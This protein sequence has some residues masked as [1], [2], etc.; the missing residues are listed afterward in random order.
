MELKT[1]AFRNPI[2]EDG[3]DPWVVSKDGYY[4]YTHTTG[5]NITLWKSTSLTGIP[6]GISKVVW[7]PPESGPQ[8]KNIWAPEIHWINDKWYIYF[9]ADDGENEN[10]RMYVLESE[11][12][13]PFGPYMNRGKIADA[14]DKWAIDGTV[15]RKDSGELFFIWSGWEGDVNVRQ[16]LY[17]APM[18]NPYT[19]SGE[20]VEIS[21]PV[22]DW[23]TIGEPHVNEGPVALVRN[24]NIYLIYSA[25]GSWTDDYC[26]GM[27]SADA[28]SDLLSPS[29]WRKH[30]LPVFSK[31]EDVFGPGHNSFVRSPDGT[32]DWIVYHAAKSKG[33]GWQRNVRMQ[34]FTWNDDLTPNLGSPVSTSVPIAK[35][36]GEM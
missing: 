21:R 1:A 2:F 3:A 6:S 28:H 33:S 16:N 20:R 36:S 34:A 18:S 12:E 13:D 26:L 10:H 4:Y 32:E 9:A 14:S 8:S 17:I 35:P 29:S 11:S 24:G 31:T 23:E 30:P 19:I 7:T 22:Y 27:L 5:S 25:S 15:L